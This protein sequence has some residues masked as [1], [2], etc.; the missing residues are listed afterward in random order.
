[1]GSITLCLL[2]IDVLHE[3]KSGNYTLYGEDLHPSIR[4][5]LSA[6]KLCVRFL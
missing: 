2:L 5:V 1:M 6:T 3:V 4:D